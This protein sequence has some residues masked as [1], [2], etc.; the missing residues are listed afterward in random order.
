MGSGVKY[1][2]VRPKIIGQVIVTK[3]GYLETTSFMEMNDVDVHIET[4]GHHKRI[5]DMYFT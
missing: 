2:P 1:N 4:I 3:S 5:K